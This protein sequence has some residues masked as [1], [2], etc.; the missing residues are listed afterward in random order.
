MTGPVQA[1]GDTAVAPGYCV[2]QENT[3]MHIDDPAFT[4]FLQ[5]FGRTVAPLVADNAV[6]AELA[7][8]SELRSFDKLAHLN[9]ADKPVG[10][11]F[12]V[13]AGIIRYYY[14]DETSGDE[15][16]GQFFEEGTVYTDAASFFSGTPSDHYIQALSACDI[17]LIPR[18]AI[19]AAFDRNHA[20]E[21]F[22]RMMM[23]QALAGSQRR[24]A[25]MLSASLEDRYRIFMGARASVARRVPQYVIA[26]YLGVTPEAL[27]RSR[28]RATQPSTK[29]TRS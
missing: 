15:R 17:M 2:E 7:R 3:V 6:M 1:D 9:V 19:F 14:L 10:H 18:T 20:L 13:H 12:F 21:R 5:L 8:S 29:T 28:R 26:S 11:L 4:A 22:G 23:E 16:T 24:T 27:A 25:A